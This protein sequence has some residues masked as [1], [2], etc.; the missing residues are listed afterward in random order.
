MTRSVKSLRTRI[1]TGTKEPSVILVPIGITLG[2]QYQLLG[3]KPPGMQNELAAT[4]GYGPLAGEGK[5]NL[6]CA[7]MDRDNCTETVQ[8]KMHTHT[9]K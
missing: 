2:N 8:V 4:I 5:V 6:A 9:D 1:L 7:F 3:H